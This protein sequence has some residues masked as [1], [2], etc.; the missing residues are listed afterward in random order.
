MYGKEA[1]NK[2]QETDSQLYTF[3]RMPTTMVNQTTKHQVFSIGFV[4]R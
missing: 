1:N 3:P 4:S 2:K